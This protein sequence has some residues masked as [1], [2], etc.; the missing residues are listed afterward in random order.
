MPPSR[1][2]FRRPFEIASKGLEAQ[3]ETVVVVLAGKAP[4]SVIALRDEPRPDAASGLKELRL[5]GA[6]S[7]HEGLALSRSKR[8]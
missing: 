1:Q 6:E 5:R 3:G 2:R 7:V 8:P 4:Q